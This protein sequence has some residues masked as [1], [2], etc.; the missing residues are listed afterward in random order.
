MSDANTQATGAPPKEKG[1]KVMRPKLRKALPTD[2][3]TFAKQLDILRAA[4][5]AS[6]NSRSPVSNEDVSKIVNMHFGTISTCNPFFLETGF[7]TRQ[8]LQNVPCEEV[9]AYAERYEWEQD[10]AA[11]KLAPVLRKSWF[12]TSLAPKLAFRS[13]SIDEAL[14]FLSEEA[15]ATKEHKDQLAILID[16]LRAAG[17][18]NVDGTVITLVKNTSEGSGDAPPAQQPPSANQTNN[19]GGNGGSRSGEIGLD[20]DPLL[21]ALL[22]KIPSQK[23]SWP[24]DK[25]LRWFRTFA[26][27][28]SQVYDDDD[29]AVEMKIDIASN[30]TNGAKQDAA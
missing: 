6:G 1:V 26:M 13:L 5:A 17:L 22:Q 4:A 14:S 25:R 28:V 3:I 23:Q 8:K 18:V 24:A 16:Y 19:S 20:L 30:G 15:G 29:T 12:Y 21:L 10:K 27:N 9:F 2:R 7:I 11:H